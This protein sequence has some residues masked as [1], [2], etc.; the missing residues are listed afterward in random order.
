M[1]ANQSL[2]FTCP[3]NTYSTDHD[4]QYTYRTDCNQSIIRPT[5]G[6]AEELLCHLIAEQGEQRCEVGEDVI[7]EV[8][9]SEDII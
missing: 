7:R 4:C 9:T 2:D 5:H 1:P 3:S 8:V 6:H